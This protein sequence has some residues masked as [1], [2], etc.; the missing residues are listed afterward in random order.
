MFILKSLARKEL[1][2]LYLNPIASG[3]YTIQTPHHHTFGKTHQEAWSDFPICADDGQFH[4]AFE[5]SEPATTYNNIPHMEKG[6]E[7]IRA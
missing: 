4:F 2:N 1:R 7:D 5:S 3:F 6:I